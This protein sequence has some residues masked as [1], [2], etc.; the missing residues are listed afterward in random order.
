MMEYS[1]NQTNEKQDVLTKWFRRFSIFRRE[2]WKCFNH[3]ETE[4]TKE[5]LIDF[6]HLFCSTL[7]CFLFYLYESRRKRE[8]WP[9][10]AIYRNLVKAQRN[11]GGSSLGTSPALF[12][13]TPLCRAR[14]VC[15]SSGIFY[16]IF[17][18]ND[19]D[20]LVIILFLR[21]IQRGRKGVI[22]K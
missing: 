7:S 21:F 20:C 13:V 8:R 17:L 9:M 18:R 19:S 11:I 4:Q 1:S 15:V 3:K 6:V 10:S 12:Y 14:V 2:C 22:A 16:F 5:N